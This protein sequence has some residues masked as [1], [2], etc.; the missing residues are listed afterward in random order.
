MKKDKNPE[1]DEEEHYK[2]TTSSMTMNKS[3]PDNSWNARDP[4]SR[5]RKTAQ[6]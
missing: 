1:S 3:K 5:M 6:K 4:R 2:P